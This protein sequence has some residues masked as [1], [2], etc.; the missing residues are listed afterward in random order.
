[1]RVDKLLTVCERCHGTRTI[2]SLLPN[3]SLLFSPG[4]LPAEGDPL[5]KE[6]TLIDAPNG[7]PLLSLPPAAMEGDHDDDGDIECI[8][9]SCF[10]DTIP[11]P[12]PPPC[13]IAQKARCL[14]QCK[15]HLVSAPPGKT[16]ISAYP[17]LLH[18]EEHTPWE[19]S[20][21]GGSLLLCAHDC[22]NH[23]LDKCGLCQPCQTLLSNTKFRNV[24]A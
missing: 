4:A 23:N 21:H 19:F 2:A 20:S 13:R 10:S 12:V 7:T 15:Q 8:G 5:P 3:I 24:L 16:V 9:S 6:S 18:V 11:D 22:K 1:V 17:F 14:V